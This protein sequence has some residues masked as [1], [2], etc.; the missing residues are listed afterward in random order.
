[1]GDWSWER[2][3]GSLFNNYYTQRCRREQYTFPWITPL[4]LDPYLIM[5]SKEVSYIIFWVFSTT[6]P[7]NENQSQAIAKHSN[8][9]ANMNKYI[10]Y[11][12]IYTHTHTHIYIYIYIYIY[13][14][15]HTYKYI[16]IYIYTHTYKYIYIYTHTHTG[17]DGDHSQRFTFFL[18][19]QWD[20]G[21]DTSF[22][23]LLHFTFHIYLI[24]LSVQWGHIQYHFW[25]FGMTQHRI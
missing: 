24:M 1:M 8:H 21:E 22:P 5:L 25:V 11:I 12:Y 4:T 20:V 3:G 6:W 19:L 14:H 18:L 16:Y 9:Y 7:R 15:T 13:T 10:I 2:P 17:V 23:R